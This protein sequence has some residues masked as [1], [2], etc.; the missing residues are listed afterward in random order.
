M[1]KKE[2]SEED[3]EEKVDVGTTVH[4]RDEGEVHLSHCSL[5]IKCSSQ[6]AQLAGIE[7]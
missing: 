5:H 2:E 3:S 1:T 7:G 4:G 6:S